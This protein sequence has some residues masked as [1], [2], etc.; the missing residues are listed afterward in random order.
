MDNGPRIAPQVPG[1]AYSVINGSGNVKAVLNALAEDSLLNVISSPSVMVLDNQTASIHVGDQ[2]PVETSNTITDGGNTI[3]SITYKDTGVQ[4]SVTPSVNAGGMVIMSIE[5]SVTDVGPVDSEGADQRTFLE[6]EINSRVA[7]RS[8]ESVVLGGLIRENKAAGSSGIPIL[9]NLPLVGPLF[10]TK[11]QE[12][13]R[14]ELLVI[15]TPRVIYSE[16]DLRDVSREMRSQMRGLD[17]ID[18]SKA[19]AFLSGRT[20]AE[21]AEV[22]Q[23]GGT[24][25]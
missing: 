4:L 15:I 6:R 7:V 12:D 19:S 17:L 20:L 18:E 13:F 5:Q 10:G 22:E 9:H 25:Q 3:S 21:P 11:T 14:T 2:V 16:S 8:S 1:F 24:E 23:Q